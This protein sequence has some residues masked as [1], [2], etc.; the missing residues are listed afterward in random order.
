M[1]EEG[2]IVAF[3]YMVG[4]GD[5]DHCYWGPPELYPE[6]YLRSRP[7]DFATFD[8]PGS[9]VCASTAA[10]LCTSYLNL[11]M[12]TLNTLKNALPLPRHCMILQLSTEDCIKATVT[13]LGL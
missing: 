9:D 5:E 1:D 8:D 11:R 7:A 12:K 4:E 13:T 3:C 6:E 2:N 10:A